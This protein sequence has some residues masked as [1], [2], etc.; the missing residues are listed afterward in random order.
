MFPIFY[1]MFRRCAHQFSW[2]RKAVDGSYYQ[3]CLRCSSQYAYD[4]ETMRRLGRIEVRPA[5]HEPDKPARRMSVAMKARYR[6]LGSNAWH[7]AT[8]ENMSQSGV[9]LQGTPLLREN[10]PVEVVLEMPEHITGTPNSKV[11]C[12]GQVVRT[13][14][15]SK[16]EPGPGFAVRLRDYRYADHKPEQPQIVEQEAVLQR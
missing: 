1:R 12:N 16:N 10:T 9:K 7:E 15:S 14:S 5:R 4:W 2:P 13:I 6:E 11:V 3:V 8:T